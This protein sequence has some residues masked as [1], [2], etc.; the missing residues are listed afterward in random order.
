MQPKII[1]K[2]FFFGL[3]FATFI[4]T[5]FIFQPFWIV[6]ILGTS[7]AIVLH[8][9][10]AWL[11]NKKLPEWLSA[12]VTLILFILL[13]C[14][15]LLGIGAI[16][17]NQSQD[18]YRVVVSEGNAQPFLYS[19][20]NRINNILPEFINFD[21][22]QRTTEFIS[23]L[24]KNI[25]N[26]FSTTVSAFFSFLLMLLIIFYLLKDGARWKKAIV[27][28]SPLQ[29]KEDERIITRLAS[30]VNAVIKGYMF[31][32]LIQGVVMG[33]GLWIFN[34]PNPALWGVVA[35]VSSLLPMIGTALVSVPAIIFLFATGNTIASLGLIIWSVVAVGTIDNFLSPIIVG[36]KIHLPSIIILFSVLGGISLLGPVGILIGPLTVSL[37][38][39]LISIYR[40]EFFKQNAIL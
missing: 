39:T 33:I 2:Y 7:F 13:L 11:K 26:I 9:V 30:S 31:V 23:Y 14:G 1:E 37:L 15:P 36:K 24:S 8:P 17:F 28:I 34:V 40:S 38:Y 21:I 10:Y 16:V 29:D 6:L 19:I 27:L 3:L 20:E 5:F 35:A 12:L 22:N 4:F 32:A 25:A 18:V